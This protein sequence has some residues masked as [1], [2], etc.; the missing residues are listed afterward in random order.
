MEKSVACPYSATQMFNIIEDV[1]S[2]TKF[3]PACCRSLILSKRSEIETDLVYS[4]H[5][6][7]WFRKWGKNIKLITRNTYMPPQWIKMEMLEG[8]LEYFAGQWS[9]HHQTRGCEIHLNCDYGMSAGLTQ[10]LLEK[11]MDVVWSALLEKM[12]YRATCLYGGK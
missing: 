3:V 7:L 9:F 8:D 12:I 4:Y 10:F 2:Y 1:N 11:Y 6:C 5:A